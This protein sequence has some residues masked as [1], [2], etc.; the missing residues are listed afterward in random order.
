M[1]D[2]EIALQKQET[3]LADFKTA[4]G[5]ARI[6]A[7]LE[8]HAELEQQADSIERSL[9]RAGQAE[10]KL[11]RGQR[12]AM[13][14]INELGDDLDDASQIKDRDSDRAR[15]ALHKVSDISR[16]SCCGAW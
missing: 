10:Y 5:I 12:L 14:M 16:T 1:N 7:Y 13:K 3:P 9:E 2:S 15:A 6:N 11:H 8:K 4:E